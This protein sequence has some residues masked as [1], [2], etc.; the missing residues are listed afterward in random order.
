MLERVMFLGVYDADE[1]VLHA[2][3]QNVRVWAMIAA[4]TCGWGEGA[5]V[6][7]GDGG[8]EI[9]LGHSCPH[10]AGGVSEIDL[11]LTQADPA[12]IV[13]ANCQALAESGGRSRKG[14][15]QRGVC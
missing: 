7:G 15:I 12:S 10:H 14:A 11:P 8:G 13:G 2:N 3:R 5:H 4:S 1:E 6:I 9:V